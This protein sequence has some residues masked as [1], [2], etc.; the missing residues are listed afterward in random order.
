MLPGK[1]AWSC[2]L[3]HP[4]FRSRVLRGGGRAGPTI[5]LLSTIAVVLLVWGGMHQDRVEDIV[6]I[7]F[8]S[9]IY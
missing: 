5:L 2:S 7:V 3:I 9:D 8:H 1:P 4:L 6:R